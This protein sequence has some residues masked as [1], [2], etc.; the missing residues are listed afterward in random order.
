MKKAVI[1]G[2]T[3]GI[4]KALSIEMAK[5][6]YELGLTGRRVEVLKEIQKK[7][8]TKVNVAKMD[9]RKKDAMSNLSSLINKM[10]GMDII[11]INSAVSYKNPDFIW[12]QEKET[13]ETNILG[14]MAIMNASVNYFK[15][16]GSGQIVGISSIAALRYSS[17]STAYCASKCF[18]SNYMGG[19]RHK[20]K[21]E[22]HKI[23]ITE[24][25]PGFVD[26]P[27]IQ[28]PG[29]KFWVVP[30]KKAAKQ[31]LDAIVKRKKH[32]Y[33]SRRWTLIGWILRI[34]PEG[35]KKYM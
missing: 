34:V 11:V 16:K 23:L 1:I 2:A 6:G 26:T 3:S 10:G 12:E 18:V 22:G 21:R 29:F 27:M 9:V 35:I 17:K 14:F 15:K 8:P 19:L 7:L 33:V 4:G 28:G 32:A 31:I 30:V 24:I 25:K 20:L 5:K 13:I